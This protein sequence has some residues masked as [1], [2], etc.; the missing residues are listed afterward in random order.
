MIFSCG[1]LQ[2]C[3]LSGSLFAIALDP[4]LNALRK[5]FDD[6]APQG[7]S[8]I[9]RACADDIVVAVPRFRG[10]ITL[11]LLFLVTGTFSGLVLQP[12]NTIFVPTSIPFSAGL[13]AGM[14]AWLEL[15]VLAW[16]DV[17]ID[18]CG[19]YLVFVCWTY[20]LL[21]SVEGSSCEVLEEGG[22]DRSG[23]GESYRVSV[24]VQR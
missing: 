14:K 12:K 13:V 10:L 18:S 16:A 21:L 19:K 7:R 1:I 24:P 4:F 23:H 6:K 11:E 17:R 8:G 9:S 5:K 3:P 22:L 2:G 20:Q 15:F